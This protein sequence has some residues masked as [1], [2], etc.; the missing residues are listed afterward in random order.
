MISV[1]DRQKPAKRSLH[2]FRGLPVHGPRRCVEEAFVRAYLEREGRRPLDRPTYR[3]TQPVGTSL[4]KRAGRQQ[5]RD[6]R[7]VA[8]RV[9][10]TQPT[11]D[12]RGLPVRIR[13]P[14]TATA[15]AV[16]TIPLQGHVRQPGHVH[17]RHQR[18]VIGS[19]RRA[20]VSG[21]PSAAAMSA[22]PGSVALTPARGSSVFFA[23]R[24]RA[25]GAT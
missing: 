19:M 10:E 25:S 7:R 8:R 11:H 20:P 15:A 5:S 12:Q 16:V 3:R 21:S 24:S 17:V 4:R 18:R 2:S 9:A 13:A 22:R 6:V 1:P 14:A 23:R